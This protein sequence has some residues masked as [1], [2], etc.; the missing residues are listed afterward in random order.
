MKVVIK[1]QPVKVSINPRTMGVTLGTP[2]VK[3]YIDVDP[4]T[5]AYS[6]TPLQETQTLATAGKRLTQDVTV[7]PIPQNYGLITWNGA[8]LTVS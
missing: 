4:Y 2:T 6:V 1:P 8:F 5:G 7:D 3:E